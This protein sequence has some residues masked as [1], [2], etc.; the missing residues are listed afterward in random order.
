M[1]R[2]TLVLFII[3]S[4]INFSFAQEEFNKFDQAG[5]RDGKWRGYYEDTK[6][7]RYEGTF[8]NGKEIG[9]FKYYDNV[10]KQQLLATREFNEA[11]TSCFT[12]FYNGKSKVSEG[13]IDNKKYQGQW[14]YFHKNSPSVM[15][16]ENYTDGQLN[17]VRKVFFP[18]EVLAEE[19]NFVKGVKEGVSK[20][21]NKKGILLEEFSY[22][23]G[24]I[25]GVINYYDIKGDL[26]IKGQYK[27]GLAV[28]MWSYFKDGQKIKEVSKD[29]KKRDRK[30]TNNTQP[31]V[32]T[33]K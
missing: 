31:A 14:R 1:K 21:Y 19:T 2:F 10:K 4:G 15:T 8:K 33:V 22:S 12:V 11:N 13:V 28:G 32:K 20:K 17:G 3:V 9:V 26:I 16:I 27:K 24:E 7:L 23:K 25:D 30:K 6:V 5:K 18:N 29:R